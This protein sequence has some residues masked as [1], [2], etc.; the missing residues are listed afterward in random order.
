MDKQEGGPRAAFIIILKLMFYLPISEAPGPVSLQR[1]LLNML[2]H[3]S[4]SI[5]RVLSPLRTR[6][7]LHIK[8]NSTHHD[9]LAY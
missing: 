6:G 7:S 3:A 4:S 2:S 8:G 5:Q 9:L 1:L